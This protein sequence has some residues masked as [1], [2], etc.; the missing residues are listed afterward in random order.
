MVHFAE[1]YRTMYYF[2]YILKEKGKLSGHPY[3]SKKKQNH[4]CQECLPRL[5]YLLLQ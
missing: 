4:Q 3:I 2:R 1:N 5:L